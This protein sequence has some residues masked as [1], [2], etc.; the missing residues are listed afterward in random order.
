MPTLVQI[1]TAVNYTSTGR[2][3]EGIGKAAL[4]AGWRSEIAFGRHPRAPASE[5]IDLGDRLG[6]LVHVV[7]IRLADRQGLHSRRATMR[8]VQSLE[9]LR[10]DVIH[11]HNLHGYYLDYPLLF[12]HL[13]AIGRPVVW[14]LHDCWTFTGHCCY[15]DAAGCT[16]LVDGCHCCPL[17]RTY[18]ASLLA[19]RSA[20]NWADKRRAFA[21]MP[22]LR[23]VTPSRWLAAQAAES[24][25]GHH[26]CDMI[27][28]G[29]DLE[30]FRP[31]PDG[32][33][34]RRYPLE[35]R[36]LVL[37]V[38]S[39]W[40]PRKG[41]DH[42]VALRPLLPR[43]TFDLAIVGVNAKEAS[44]LPSGIIP[45]RRT[46]STD[47]LAA[48]YSRA[49]AFVN[50]TLAD[51]FPLTNLEA[52]A[53][54]TPVVTYDSG[55]SPEAIDAGTGGAVARGDV[56]AAARAIE[57][58]A[59]EDRAAAR[60][61][62]RE[63][64]NVM[65]RVETQ[66]DRYVN[67][68][69]TSLPMPL[70]PPANAGSR[71]LRLC[72]VIPW[73]GPRHSYIENDLPPA[74]AEQG[75][76]VRGVTSEFQPDFYVADWNDRYA[77]AFGP[78]RFPPGDYRHG[79]TDVRRLRSMAIRRWVVLRGLR[80]AVTDFRP[81][82]IEASGI[83]APLTWQ[84]AGIARRLSVPFVVSHHMPR[85]SATGTGLLKRAQAVIGR[86]V[87]G[88]TAGVFFVSN[89]ARSHA[90]ER[91]GRLP[92]HAWPMP[93]GVDTATFCPGDRDSWTAN[94]R[95]VRQR[96]GIE[97]DSPLVV[98]TGRLEE[99]KGMGI[100]AEAMKRLPASGI[101]FA[102]AGQGPCEPLLKSCPGSHLLGYLPEAELV[103]LYRACDLAVWP[104]SMSV[105]QLHVLACGSRLLVPAPHP[106]PELIEC[107]AE[108]FPRG[109]EA[110]LTDSV[111]R[112]ATRRPVTWEQAVGTARA[113]AERCSWA[114]IAARR[115]VCYR[116][117]L[118][119]VA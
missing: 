37:A 49:T 28:Y 34:L 5:T 107:G 21:D 115:I 117:I 110:A 73:Y 103:D 116:E 77:G 72:W 94:R 90:V 71:R 51:N 100:L 11:L 119:E 39:E 96:L 38:A 62:C 86:R 111:V 118:A 74:L 75:V 4:A 88:K 45:I 70:E 89:E 67:L 33:L 106:K 85:G 69:G 30:A 35:R 40:D 8:L 98:Y 66:Y 15:F 10:P 114:A 25:L 79:G 6:T 87:I 36:H 44:R 26:S 68:S 2:I 113:A 60:T 42:V 52:L 84:A 108:T 24:F 78:N 54:G 23:L 12:R 53:C 58:I 99:S 31:M 46:D 13:R 101:H 64:S 93:L 104:D 20:G 55:G 92:G 29:I 112:L 50:L 27:P 83:S 32:D 63:R 82:I 65:F 76:D 9:R 7:V 97:A 56:A 102:F 47:E 95:A 91:Y 18:P 14:S 16:K 109:D 57:R 80:R 81:D 22:R 105:S 61:R 1:N 43:D 48:L 19:N 41:L 17:I 59:E 3:A